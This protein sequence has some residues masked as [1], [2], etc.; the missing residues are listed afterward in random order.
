MLI[1]NADITGSLTINGVP[2][3]TGSYTGIFKSGTNIISGNTVILTG[4]FTGSF[5][6]EGS[7]LSGVTSYTD[8]DTLSFIQGYSGSYS[9]SFSGSFF[10]DGSNLSG[11][12]SYTDADT[13]DFINSLNVVSGSIQTVSTV[14]DTFTSATS[15]TVT[16]NFGTKEVIVSVYENDTLIFPSSITTPTVNTV[17]ITFPEP[18]TGRVVVV[19]AGH[20]VSGSIN[21]NSVLNKPT[22]VSGSSQISFTGITNKPTL[23]SGS[24]QITYSGL[25]GIPN[26]IVSGSS[27]VSFTGITNKP[28]LISGSSQIAAL[29][30]ATT[31]SNQFNGN[32][33]I[34]GSLTVSG[35]V[36]AQTLNIQQVT[37]SIVFSSGSNRFGNNT[38]NTHQFTGSVNISGSLTTSIATLGTAATTFLTSDSG[39]IKSRTAAQTLSDI[40]G[41]AT[42]SYV[43]VAT[44]QSITGQKTFTKNIDVNGVYVGRGASSGDLFGGISGNTAIGSQALLSI[45]TGYPNTAVGAEA[46][47]N[48]TTGANNIAVGSTAGKLISAGTA[49]ETS[50]TSIYIG[51][52]TRPSANGNTNEIVIGHTTTGNGSNTVTIGNSSITNTYLKGAVTLTG[53]LNGTSASFSQD[54]TFHGVTIGRGGGGS[55]QSF[56]YNT[57]IGSGALAANTTG[58]FNTAIGFN[59]LTN[60]TTGNSQI[61][62]GLNAGRYINA[63]TANITSAT[64]IYLG[65]DTRASANGN[66][67]E[68][69]IGHEARGNGSNTV[70][71]GNDSITN[72]YLKGAVTL[73]AAL[74]GTSASFSADIQSSTFF[75]SN[76]ATTNS[77]TIGVSANANYGYIGNSNYWGFRTGT[78]G[79]FNIDVNNSASPINALKITQAGAAT[80]S[81]SVSTKA[82][83]STT[84]GAGNLTAYIVNSVTSASGSTGYGL[85]I[86]SEASAAT[87]YALTVRNLAG[88]NTYFH[89]STETGKVGNVGIGT[90]T[91]TNKLH[92]TG[93][94][95][96]PS[97]RL[98]SLSVGFHWDIGRENASTGD[99]VFNN[100]N[101]STGTTEKMRI[102]QDSVAYLRMASGTGGI[103][104]NGDTAA[105][106]ALDDYEEGT[107]TPVPTSTGAT[108]NTTVNGTYTKIGRL[109][110]I[111]CQLDNSSAPT[112][113]LTN[114][115]SI[116]GLPF[117][118]SPATGYGASL[119][120]GFEVYIDYPAGGLG[121]QAII[122]A[123]TTRIS[124]RFT[125]DDASGD[126]FLASNFDWGDARIALSGCYEV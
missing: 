125:K 95:S 87:S 111:T 114:E 56:A 43:T 61:A 26:G 104:F 29:G 27:Q 89:V 78:A 106:N 46:L 44:N 49:N 36:V 59:A 20:I 6:G 57:A 21:Y 107:W 73:T 42:G 10:G 51:N 22:L 91:P 32:Q 99:F 18:V 77:I 97:L 33:S 67:N 66:T 98:G 126:D 34:T 76:T 122:P 53:A 118:S 9:G 52:D 96:T 117:T 23:V 40:G 72:T 123:N 64:S 108:F 41:Q 13:L 85:A 101:T 5:L 86:E 45:S 92:L 47:R 58:I 102:T 74:N 88:S 75:R 54:S 68:I 110:Y 1:H 15:Y 50:T 17:T 7:Q 93:N 100:T 4:S 28:T 62:V 55:S 24:S 37:S 63:G 39:T 14:S 124:L 16:H 11:V 83:S 60:H 31:G 2:Y 30:Y 84:S 81:S 119:A 121:I 71:L 113:T 69:V 3:N 80:F 65:V 82:L 25:T 105:A 120:I 48:I 94:T 90:D 79:D 8:A 35:Q 70:T 19:K 115:M 12:T 109:V 112:G 116:T 38:G 103:Q